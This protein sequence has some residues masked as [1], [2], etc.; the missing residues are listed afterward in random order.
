MET[1]GKNVR[2]RGWGKPQN[3]PSTILRGQVEG[4]WTTVELKEDGV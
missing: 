2:C 1:L 3:T 4:Q